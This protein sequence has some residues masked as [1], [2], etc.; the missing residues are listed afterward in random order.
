M[1]KLPEMRQL[2]DSSD[3]GVVYGYT[4]EGLLYAV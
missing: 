3:Q 1:T 4:D 2:S